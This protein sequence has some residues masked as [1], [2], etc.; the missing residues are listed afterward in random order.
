MLDINFIRENSEV[1]KKACKNKN[2]NVDVDRVLALDKGK[3]E[4][5]TEMEALKSEQNKIS[6]GGK[7]NKEIFAQ[8]KEIKE[9]IKSMEP[10]LAKINAEDRKSVV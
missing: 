9:K 8:A 3:R 10:D 2:A 7:D 1:V 6:R 5:M 4:L